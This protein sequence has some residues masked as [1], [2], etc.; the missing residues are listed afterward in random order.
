MTVEFSQQSKIQPEPLTAHPSHTTPGGGDTVAPSASR[1]VRGERGAEPP[2]WGMGAC[3]HPLIKGTHSLH[4]LLS[5][6]DVKKTGDG[7]KSP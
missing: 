5:V 6:A 2:A 3:P 4:T 1:R 7:A